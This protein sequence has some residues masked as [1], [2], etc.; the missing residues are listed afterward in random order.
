MEDGLFIITGCNQAPVRCIVRDKVARVLR[1]V[2]AREL[3]SIGGS[4]LFKQI[5]YLGYYWSMMEVD[6]LSFV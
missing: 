6:S 1:E 4:K 2:Y 3:M 5:I